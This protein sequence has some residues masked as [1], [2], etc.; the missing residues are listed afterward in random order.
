M[1]GQAS[2]PSGAELRGRSGPAGAAAH[3]WPVPRPAEDGLPLS[4]AQQRLWFLDQLAPGQRR[5]QHP[6]RAAAGRAPWTVPGAGP[7]APS[8]PPRGPAHHLRRS[9]GGAPRRWSPPPWRCP[10]RW[11]T[12]APCPRAARGGGGGAWREEEAGRRS[13]WRRARCCG[14]PLLRLG[15]RRARAAA[16]PAPHRR[17]RLVHGRPGA[18]AGRALRRLPAGG[19]RRCRSCRCSTPTT[20]PGSGGGC[21]ARCWRGSSPTGGRSSPALPGGPGAAHRP[22]A[23]PCR[24]SRRARSTCG[25]PAGASWRAVRR[26][27]ARGAP[28]CSWCC[29]P[30]F[31]ALLGRYSGQD[32]VA[33]GTPV[34]GRPARAR[35]ADRLLRQHPGAAGRPRRPTP[36]SGGCWPGC[37]RPAW[38]PTPTR[39]SPSSA[40]RG[41][42]ARARPEPHPPVPGDARP[43]ERA[44]AAQPLCPG[45]EA[46]AR[47]PGS[48]RAR[49]ST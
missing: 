21:G 36:R 22:P 23:R 4:F 45:L 27:P 18:R 31:Q 48:A 14:R 8:S 32:D 33:V 41:A 29:W 6:R 10:C 28:R 20:R 26:W 47:G 49:S 44:P 42:A 15:D 43:A 34:A 35:G 12:S 1:A 39:T 25:A 37:G 3:A 13:T 40:G 46:Q 7:A 16:D 38:G 5:L 24:P 17:R 11:S 9:S 2:P 30:A 19:S